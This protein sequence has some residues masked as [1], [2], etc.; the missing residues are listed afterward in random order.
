MADAEFSDAAYP[1]ANPGYGKRSVPGQLPPTG[2]DFGHLRP[3][4]AD[5]ASF[6]DRR[7][8]NDD[9]SLKTLAKY[10]VY[11]QTAVGSALR[12]LVAAGHLRRGLE[13]VT[14]ESGST[15][16]VTRT[17][18]SR[19]PRDDAW[20]DAYARGE[21]PAGTAE[22]RPP[23]PTRSRAYILLAALGRE[24]P[25]LSLSHMDCTLL[26]PLVEEWFSRDATERQ[27]LHALTVGLPVPVHHPA[28][29]VRRRL[30]DKLP[31]APPP[32]PDRPRILECSEC[33]RPPGA[34]V[35]LRRGLCDRCRGVPRMDPPPALPPARVHALAAEAR[36]AA[37]RPPERTP[38]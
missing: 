17:W 27:V 20:W 5:I 3:R 30:R 24:N 18:W 23:R 14:S 4:D 15:L 31:P 36:A 38:V 2:N 22:S 12:A 9:I 29:L 34:G 25:A 37:G 6:I 35:V 32:L 19:T 33:G 11:G 10:T 26:A 8:D 16:W 28:A 13:A 1:V 7:R 21:L